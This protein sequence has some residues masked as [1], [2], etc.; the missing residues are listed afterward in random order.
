MH[1][2]RPSCWRRKEKRLSVWKALSL[3]AWCPEPDSNWHT[4]RRR[5]LNPLRLPI[6][7]SGRM[8]AGLSLNH[9]LGSSESAHGKLR[10]S[11]LATSVAVLTPVLGGTRSKPPSTAR[12]R[13]EERSGVF[14]RQKAL[15]LTPTFSERKSPMA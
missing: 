12:T 2:L 14:G 7:P 6:P 11:E 5:I 8:E 10:D 4:F 3:N 15:S 9:F 1:P 13:R